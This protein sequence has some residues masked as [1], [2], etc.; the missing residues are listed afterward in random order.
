[1]KKSNKEVLEDFYKLYEQNQKEQ[2]APKTPNGYIDYFKAR[3]F[4]LTELNKREKECK[5]DYIVE[6]LS[7]YNKAELEGKELDFYFKLRTDL[8]NVLEKRPAYKWDK[9]A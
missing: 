2:K 7:E 3:H 6:V 9:K 1:M 5:K 8:D 4:L